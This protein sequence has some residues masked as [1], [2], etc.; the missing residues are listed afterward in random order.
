MMMKCTKW[1]PAT[2]LCQIQ[3]VDVTTYTDE[4]K[5]K[6]SKGKCENPEA[7]EACPRFQ[8]MRLAGRIGTSKKREPTNV[9]SCAV[10]AKTREHKSLSAS[11]VEPEA[12]R[13]KKDGLAALDTF[14]K[15]D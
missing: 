11:H 5:A 6:V 8:S 9:G 7:F 14:K 13:I 10:P 1:I 2:G 4:G 12:K 15:V 3:S